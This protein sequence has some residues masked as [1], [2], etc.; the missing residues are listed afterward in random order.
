MRS[1]RKKQ[2]MTLSILLVVILVISVGFAAFSSTL[3]INSEAAV[4]PD[5]STFDVK[6]SSSSTAL[7]TNDIKAVATGDASGADAVIDNAS[8]PTIT[9]LTANFTKPG[10]TV[11]YNF[12]VRNVGKYLAHLTSIVFDNAIGALGNKECTALGQTSNELVQAACSGI[13]V[14]VEV[15]G[16]TA[17]KTELGIK[18]STLGVNESKEVKVTISYDLSATRADGPFSIE[19]GSIYLTYGTV[20]T[21]EMPKL[22]TLVYDAWDG[23]T[24]TSLEQLQ[25]D[26]VAKTV[27][28]TSAAD[29]AGVRNT[30]NSGELTDYDIT[31]NT[32]IDLGSNE[33]EP[34]G[35]GSSLDSYTEGDSYFTGTIN[36]NGYAIKGL[37]VVEETSAGAG[38]IGT[39][40][41]DV[42]IENLILEGT[43]TG[44]G[45]AVGGLIG[46]AKDY[47]G[48]TNL[49]VKNSVID[50]DV[51]A[52]TAAGGI[53]GRV[54]TTG[55]VT[56]EGVKNTGTITGEGG[57][58][59]GLI[60]ITKY[61]STITITDS[62]NEGTLSGSSYVAGAIGYL[63]T[64]D[65][66]ITGFI[67]SGEITSN[68]YGGGV[69]GYVDNSYVGEVKIDNSTN[70][71][72]ITST[73]NAGGIAAQIL[74]PITIKN[75]TNN[76]M[77]V[78]TERHAGGII[79][80][81][82]HGFV[83]DNCTNTGAIQSLSTVFI[84]DSNIPP[85]AGGIIGNGSMDHQ[86]QSVYLRNNN[87]GNASITVASSNGKAG[88]IMGHFAQPYKAIEIV[89]SGNTGLDDILYFGT[90][91][92]TNQ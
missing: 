44:T 39:A 35:K 67:N 5:S 12:Y 58:L 80:T 56:L 65:V 47:N 36:G 85:S 82:N 87:G 4:N 91:N 3:R 45:D 52:T 75:S 54:Y 13:S 28:V 20:E 62:Q 15:D 37:N 10:E 18:G 49:T 88:R 34:L 92:L 23:V 73:K 86:D 6:F 50:V 69:L 63:T 51:T 66:S 46:F 57:S 43:V 68:K 41:G 17:T 59:G 38:F 9:N 11:T 40:T 33:W 72:N 29:L 70:N 84:L 27:S 14:K 48:T 74:R 76:G 21:N 32:S 83:V 79:G 81:V 1:E 19:F 71:A 24:A 64:G 8:N 42:V 90:N 78:S 31:L 53:A 30:V 55:T 89:V 60:G 25:K 22:P 2:I 61:D 16:V 77:I 7:E 26:D